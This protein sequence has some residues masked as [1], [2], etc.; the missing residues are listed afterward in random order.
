MRIALRLAGLALPV[1][2]AACSGGGSAPDIGGGTTMRSIEG[3]P[4]GA[5]PL[6][7]EP[8]NIWSD[9]LLAPTAPAR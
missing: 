7:P 5:A 1:L 8:G 9:G 6:Q 2:M 3:S 4:S